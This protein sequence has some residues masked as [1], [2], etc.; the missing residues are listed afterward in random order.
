MLFMTSFYQKVM[1]GDDFCHA[2]SETK[3]QFI[4]GKIGTGKYKAAIAWAPF[5][6]YGP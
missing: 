3:R 1:S 5:V 4:A 6:Y 2:A